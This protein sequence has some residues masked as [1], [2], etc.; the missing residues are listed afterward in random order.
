MRKILTT[1]LILVL[2][3]ICVGIVFSDSINFDVKGKAEN[4]SADT[5]AFLQFEQELIALNNDNIAAPN[6]IET[7]D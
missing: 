7:E 6:D 4:T 1:S 5:Q 2:V 3:V